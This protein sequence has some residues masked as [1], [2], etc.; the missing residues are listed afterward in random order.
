M[1]NVMLK[2]AAKA[3][4]INQEGKALLLR[5]ASTYEEGTNIGKWGV[6]GGESTMTRSFMMV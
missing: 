2:V 4:I 6:P 5:E 3:V 1:S